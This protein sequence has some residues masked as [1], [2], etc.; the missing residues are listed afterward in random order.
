MKHCG[1]WLNGEP[2]RA[3]V[4]IKRGPEA[5]AYGSKLKHLLGE[6]KNVQSKCTYHLAK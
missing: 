5:S 1:M 6:I 2:K 4:A 3:S